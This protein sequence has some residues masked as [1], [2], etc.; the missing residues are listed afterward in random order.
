MRANRP[1]KPYT[2]VY[3]I[4]IAIAINPYC[5]TH[6]GYEEDE[7]SILVERDVNFRYSVK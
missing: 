5:Y 7:I 3:I 2:F 4:D 1:L 6:Y